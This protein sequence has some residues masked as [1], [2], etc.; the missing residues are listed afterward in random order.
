MDGRLCSKQF[1][2]DGRT[3][4]DCTKS[5][6]PD[7]EQTT[8]E[9]CYVDSSY[10]SGKKWDY[11]TPIM[12]YDRVRGANNN[13]LKDLTK[14]CSSINSKISTNI[15]PA[16]R[17]L[18]L[19]NKVKTYQDGVLNKINDLN[20]KLTIILKNIIKLNTAKHEGDKQDKNVK[21]LN[22]TI[23]QK[24]RE[25]KSK[26]DE[27]DKNPLLGKKTNNCKGMLLYEDDD[28]GDGLIGYYYDNE[29]WLGNHQQRT[30]KSI[31][32][33]WTDTSP[34][35]NINPNNFSV[36]WE[37]YIFIP[38]T[39]NYKFSI[40]LDGGAEMSLDGD[41]IIDY[42]LG[43][44]ISA[45][46]DGNNNGKNDTESG[47]SAE[48][49]INPNKFTS[50]K[51]YLTGGTKR[52][53]VIKYFHSVHTSI[54]SEEQVFFKFYWGNDEVNEVMVET[55]Y[56]FSA[57][58]FAPL[59]ITGYNTDENQLR[60]LHE[61]DFAYINSDK[62]ILQDI[63]PK[64]LNS[65]MLKFKTRYLSEEISIKINSPS[66]VYVGILSHY[67]NPLPQSYTETGYSM[68][69]IQ[70]DKS[71]QK[72]GKKFQ[73][74]K[75]GR[76]NIYKK[77]YNKGAIQIRLKKL[78]LN[79]KGIPL[80]LFF[81][82]D[83]SQKSPLKCA[84]KVI[85]ISQSTSPYFKSCTASS[86]KPGYKCEDGFSGKNRDEEGGMWAANSDGVGAYIRVKFVRI[87]EITK[88]IYRNRKN[89]SERNSMLELLFDSG[90]SYTI[91]LKNNDEIF[92]YDINSVRA[93]GVKVT[94]KDVF[95]TSNNGGSFNFLGLECVAKDLPE[96][97][98]SENENVPSLFKPNK[99][100]P[101]NLSCYDSLSNSAKFENFEVKENFKTVVRCPES[102]ALIE[103]N[104]YG[105]IFYSFDSPLCKSAYHS[106][107]LSTLGGLVI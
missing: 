59:K 98:I 24:I 23:E 95:G 100:R 66:M 85:N 13:S 74:K 36:K 63:P 69:L 51:I 26:K 71:D 99:N 90:D 6:T 105:D 77:K 39:S 35:P 55:K 20:K 43:S 92:E 83:G 73:A 52:K 46:I 106:G 54:F 37:G 61:N 82:F 64:F 27:E 50:Q 45:F 31:F 1:A 91:P 103:N 102:C 29:F 12:D 7:G 40:E 9:W 8:R 38:A 33:D 48:K 4:F 70:V 78:G 10:T 68:S 15:T 3:Y 41:K 80:V 49:K 72:N 60:K 94:I 81:G 96:D 79:D 56:L 17:S 18:D 67:P 101:V 14:F 5:R 30:D 44:L 57:F 93:Q 65:F 75:S 47:D 22:L 84:G 76:I 16:Q 104:I 87:F 2:Q 97:P 25:E 88:L 86:E 53:I 58:S 19:L 62:Y 21:D 32:F 34:M 89:P 28:R 107:K 11:C 42:R